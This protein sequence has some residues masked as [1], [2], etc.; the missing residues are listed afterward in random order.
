MALTCISSKTNVSVDQEVLQQWIDTAKKYTLAEESQINPRTAA[1]IL[2]VGDE[3][4][5]E[6]IN[7]IAYHRLRTLF[8]NNSISLTDQGWLQGV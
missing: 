1:L 7:K 2:Q 8:A 4:F 6:D 5:Y 3:K